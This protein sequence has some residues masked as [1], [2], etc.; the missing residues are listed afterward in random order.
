MPSKKYRFTKEI[1]LDDEKNTLVEEEFSETNKIRIHHKTS[2]NKKLDSILEKI[3]QRFFS[4]TNS[5]LKV[6]RCFDINNSG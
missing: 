2:Q 6:F 4:G 3:E 5:A 1:K